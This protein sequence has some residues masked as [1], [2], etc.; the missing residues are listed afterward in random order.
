MDTQTQRALAH[1]RRTE[2]LGYLIQKQGE[3][4]T[5]ES[6][7][8]DSLGLTTAKAKYHL[9]VLCDADLISHTFA[10]D[11]GATERYVAGVSAGK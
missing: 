4:G 7:L 6:E 11:L 10:R 8:A 1:P 2:I 3:G 9:T 5:D